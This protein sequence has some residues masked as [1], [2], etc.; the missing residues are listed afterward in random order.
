MLVAH[1]SKDVDRF[2]ELADFLEDLFPAIAVEGDT[3]DALAV[4][5]FEIR[6]ED[7]SL[8]YSHSAGTEGLPDV[9][10]LQKALSGVEARDQSGATAAGCM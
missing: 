2:I 9:D 3:D 1:N 4:G 8:L 5:T 6:G 10:V 7:G